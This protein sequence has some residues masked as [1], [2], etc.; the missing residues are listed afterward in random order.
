MNSYGREP[1]DVE[2][3]HRVVYDFEELDVVRY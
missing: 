2:K 1:I 3:L